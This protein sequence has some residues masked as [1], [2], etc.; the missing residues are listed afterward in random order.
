MISVCV[1]TYNG[2]KYIK[3]QLI[4][5]LEQLGDND[6]IIISDNCSNDSTIEIIN[7]IDDPRIK[8]FQIKPCS[9]VPHVAITFNFENALKKAKGDFVYL[10]DQDDIWDKNKISIFSKYFEEGYDLI[11]SDFCV[12]DKNID[13]NN[14]PFKGKSPYNNYLIFSPKYF[15]C[16]MAFNRYIKDC[17]LPFPKNL[18]LHDSWIG[19]LSEFVGN[20]KFINM[21]LT[22]RRIHDLNASENKHNKLLYKISY[23]LLFFISLLT[24]VCNVKYSKNGCKKNN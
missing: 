21:P 5:I 13:I 16:C 10:S 11:V 20:V 4:S 7:K 1:A 24:R 6:E 23:R 12:F 22:Y 2:S 19:C 18:P 9:N 15:G 3:E 14:R 17:S 8:I